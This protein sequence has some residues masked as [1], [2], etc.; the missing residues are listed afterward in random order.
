[1]RLTVHRKAHFNA[2]HRLFKKEWTDEKN[3]EVFGKCSNPNYHG[4]NYELTVSVTGEVDPETGFVMDLKRLKDLIYTEVET[5]FDHKNLN[6]EVEEFKTL[7]PTAENITV[8][9][10]N[11][12]REKLRENLDLQVTLYE[13]PRNF[14]TYKGE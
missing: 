13:T 12:L 2:A 3:F 1:M 10:W 8:V 9:I 14:V 6:V 11:K 5:P 4:H 7:N